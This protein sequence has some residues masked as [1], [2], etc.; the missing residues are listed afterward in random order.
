[1]LVLYLLIDTPAVQRSIE[2]VGSLGYWGAL[3]VGMF[4]VSVFTVAP[5]SVILLYLADSHDPWLVA[6]TAGL[7]AVIGDYLIFRYLR[8]RV[9]EELL[10]VLRKNGRPVW[11]LFKTPFFSW[12]IPIVGALMIASAMPDEVGIGLLGASRI[13]TWQFLILTF[14]LNAVGIFA[15][16]SLAQVEANQ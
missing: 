8:D 12:S 7:G 15:L 10:P 16:I 11:L 6:A 14:L 9:F 1:V 3:V 13:K 4:F 2:A 5:A